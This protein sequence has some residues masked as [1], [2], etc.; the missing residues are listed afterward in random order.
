MLPDRTLNSSPENS[1]RVQIT[2][3]NIHR[4]GADKTYS[5]VS[6]IPHPI[7]LYVK[8]ILQ[9][10]A[11]NLKSIFPIVKKVTGK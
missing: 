11:M 3:F 8:A 2:A 10:H 6:G 1:H 4:Q 5:S 7:L 9:W